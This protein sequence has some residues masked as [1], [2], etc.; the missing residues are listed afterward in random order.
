M[1]LKYFCTFFFKII[2]KYRISPFKSFHY[3]KRIFNFR[4][5]EVLS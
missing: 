1:A 4:Y 2:H 5:I 3:L